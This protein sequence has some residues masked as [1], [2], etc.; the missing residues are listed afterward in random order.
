MLDTTA[1]SLL[2]VFA[3]KFSGC[4]LNFAPENPED[5]YKAFGHITGYNSE[6]YNKLID[7]AHAAY[8]SGD[9][10]LLSQK[11]HEAE[12]LLL[13]DMPVIPVFEYQNVVLRSSKLS[14]VKYSAWGSMNFTRAKLKNWQNYV[15]TD[16]E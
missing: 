9:K 5:L 12:K 2:S 11:L 15:P 7:E 4:Q 16:E 8:L 6:A 13:A 1:F 3:E 14:G 10:N